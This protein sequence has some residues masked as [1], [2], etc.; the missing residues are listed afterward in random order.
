MQQRVLPVPAHSVAD[1]VLDT[2][3]LAVRQSSEAHAPPGLAG[4]QRP[5]PVCLVGVDGSRGARSALAVAGALTRSLGGSLVL[6]HC[7]VPLLPTAVGSTSSALG[8]YRSEVGRAET[9]LRASAR[10]LSDVVS[11]WE[12]RFGDPAEAICRVATELRVDLIVVGSRGPGR[13]DR[14]LLGSVSRAVV[15]QA[16]CS[17]LVVRAGTSAGGSA[18]GVVQGAPR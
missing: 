5:G 3:V 8:T 9:L 17:V 18:A 16:P 11:R 4:A 14:L 6:V 12:L 7:L 13:L 1:S 10:K 2:R 15:E